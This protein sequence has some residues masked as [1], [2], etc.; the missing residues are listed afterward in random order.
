MLIE[1]SLVQKTDGIEERIEIVGD[2]VIVAMYRD[3][4]R[5]GRVAFAKHVALNRAEDASQS[6]RSLR[7]SGGLELVVVSL[8]IDLG[9]EADRGNVKSNG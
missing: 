4:F 5:D 6:G 1:P 9:R 7:D 8:L 3:R 2:E